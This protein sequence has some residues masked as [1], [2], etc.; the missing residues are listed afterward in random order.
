VRQQ[1]REFFSE[2]E[3]IRTAISSPSFHSTLGFEGWNSWQATELEGLF[4]VP[5]L[6]LGFTKRDQIGRVILRTCAIEFKRSHWKRALVQAFRYSAFAHY[7][8]VL[9]DHAHCRPAIDSLEAFKRSNIGLL[10]ADY[11]GDISCHY[12]PK[13][14]MPYSEGLHR[15]LSG[16]VKSVMSQERSTPASAA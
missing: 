10:T 4:G 3:L 8:F 11:S 2:S 14:Q 1:Q 9:L 15:V 13:F 6:V 7:S 16:L 12:R 5:D